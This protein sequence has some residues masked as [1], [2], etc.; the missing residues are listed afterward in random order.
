MTTTEDKP[1]ELLEAERR[2]RASQVQIAAPPAGETIDGALGKLKAT[3]DRVQK[4]PDASASDRETLM[5]ISRLR[6][7]W[8]APKRHVERITL[9][10]DATEWNECHRKLKAMLG[11]G[12]TV[13][14]VGIRGPGKT[15]MAV[16]L[17]R[18]VTNRQR[19]AYYCSAMDYFMRIKDAFHPDRKE[20]QEDAQ[21]FFAKPRLLVVDEMHVRS[22]SVWEDNML[23]DLINKRYNGLLDTVLISNETVAQFTKSVG[24]S[25]MD[26][27][28]ETGG[29]VEATWPSFR[30]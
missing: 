21:R 23:A 27:L 20:R 22:D 28:N 14:L 4:L 10:P 13:A 2:I 30:Q 3:L 25:I 6:E 8:N 5:A 18:E 29:I 15:Q 19:T 24:A 7:T 12:F 17:M 9:N 26:R 1:I 16:E 11:S